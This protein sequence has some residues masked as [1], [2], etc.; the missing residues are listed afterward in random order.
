MIKML[1]KI[2]LQLVIKIFVAILLT[3][4]EYQSYDGGQSSRHLL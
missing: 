4:S 2:F 3:F 1:K